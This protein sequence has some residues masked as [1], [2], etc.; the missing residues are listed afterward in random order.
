MPNNEQINCVK[1]AQTKNEIQEKFDADDICMKCNNIIYKN[2]EITCK[3]GEME[4]II[5]E[6]NKL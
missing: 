6:T 1:N 3:Y 2:G 5:D 4:D